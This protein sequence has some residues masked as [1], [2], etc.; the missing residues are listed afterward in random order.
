MIK[1]KLAKFR[2]PRMKSL[3]ML[4]PKGGTVMWSAVGEAVEVEDE[5]AFKLL[6]ECG[7]ML[8]MVKERKAVKKP[9]EESIEE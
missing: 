1:L 5:F 4:N 6:S 8:E 7:D 9:K 2:H 3:V